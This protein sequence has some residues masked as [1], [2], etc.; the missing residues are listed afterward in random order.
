MEE[1]RVYHSIWDFS[2]WR[3]NKGLFLVSALLFLGI[4]HFTAIDDRLVSWCL[5]L[6]CVLG[7]A[8]LLCIL[9]N[10]IRAR[11]PYLIIN[12]DGIVVNDKRGQWTVSFDEVKSFE[13]EVAKLWRFKTRT[14]EIIVH[15]VNGNGYCR[16][17]SAGGLTIN[18][19]QLCDLLN[20]RL[21]KA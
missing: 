9:V 14:D 8:F 11:H 13:C 20:E 16:M 3:L 10:M 15:L 18:P 6:V 2:D 17:F 1:I 19:Q 7:T 21:V 5:F 4:M 12:V